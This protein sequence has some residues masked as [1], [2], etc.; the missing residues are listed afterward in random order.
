MAEQNVTVI[1]SIYN[2]TNGKNIE[3]FDNL[4]DALEFSKNCKEP[5][6]IRKIERWNDGSGRFRYSY[7]RKPVPD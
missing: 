1:Y 4:K 5:H 2:H 3:N 6:W 7:E